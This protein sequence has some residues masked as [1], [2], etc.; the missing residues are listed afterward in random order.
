MTTIIKANGQHEP[1][2]EQKLLASVKRAGIPHEIQQEVVNHITSGL[3]ENIHTSEIYQQ[4]MEYLAK[5]PESHLRARYSLKQAIMDLGPT[6]YPFEDYVARILQSLGFTTSVRNMIRG[7]CVMHEID[8]IAEKNSGAT[9]RMMVEAKYH[10]H[11]GITTEIHVA[12][13]TQ[14]RFQDIKAHNTFTEVMLITNTKASTDAIAYA[15]C[16]GMKIIGWD[17]PEGGS[18][19]ELVEKFSLHP[20]TTLTSLSL[21]SKQQLLENGVVL[22][23]DLC[24]NEHLLDTLNL[25]DQDRQKIYQE[26]LVVCNL[27]KK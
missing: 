7:K 24:R 14:A 4:I 1:F 11:I 2:S 25:S 26:A 6:G 20:I 9:D 10:N 23:S 13:Y 5:K 15:N 16:M 18:L 27:E 22:C 21:Q 8:V 3:Y 12:M 17:Y 19:R